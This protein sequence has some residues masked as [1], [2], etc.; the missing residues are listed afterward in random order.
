MKFALRIT[1]L[2]KNYCGFQKQKKD[3]AT[4][5]ILPSIQETLEQIVSKML[6][7]KTSIVPSGRTDAGVHAVGQVVHFRCDNPK[8]TEEIFRRGLNSHLPEDIRVM[9]AYRVPDDF[10]AQRSA[11][12]KQYSYCFQQGPSPLPH[13]QD[14][15]W[16]IYRK[17]DLKAMQ[18]ALDYLKGEHDFFAFQGKK[19]KEL[20]STVRTILEAELIQEPMPSHLGMDLNELG[21]SI[22]RIRLVGTGFLKQMVRGIAGTI[23]QVGEGKR[24]PEDL[25]MIL[26]TKNRAKVGATAPAKGLTL[27]RVWYKPDLS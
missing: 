10:H 5:P 23:L 21:Y 26:E 22:I 9:K 11:T 16:W 25:K 1:Y 8:F 15:T 3:H 19:A 7:V 27:D 6:E 18:M 14:T 4:A 17:L 13:L 12:H 20:K 2:G 24:P